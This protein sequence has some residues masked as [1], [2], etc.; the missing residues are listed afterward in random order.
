MQI[1]PVKV[2]NQSFGIDVYQSIDFKHPNSY[3]Q[4][5]DNLISEKYGQ[6]FS[7]GNIDKLYRFM[8][9]TDEFKRENSELLKKHFSIIA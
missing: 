1:S 8:Q 5:L 3:E 9:A 6:F 4:D 2:N 7:V